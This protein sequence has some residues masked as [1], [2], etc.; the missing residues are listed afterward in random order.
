MTPK[1]SKTTKPGE[2][3]ALTRLFSEIDPFRDFFD[4]PLWAS[5]LFDR[6]FG[7]AS[8]GTIWAPAMDVTETRDAYVVTLELAGTSKDDISIECHEGVLTIR[9]EK[10]NEREERDEHRHYTERTFGSFSRTLRL[11]ADASDEVKATFREGVLT[12]SIQKVAER[13][14]KVV[15]IDS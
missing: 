2:V 8:A 12:V 15:S 1:S 13:K 11:P 7:G 14:P 3:P 4:R 9:G 10:K 6:P 5:R